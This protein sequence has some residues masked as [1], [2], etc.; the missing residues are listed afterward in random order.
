MQLIKLA[1]AVHVRVTKRLTSV[2]PSPSWHNFVFGNLT[3]WRIRAV[4]VQKCNSSVWSPAEGSAEASEKVPLTLPCCEGRDHSFNALPLAYR[5]YHQGCT[6]IV[7]Q[8][9]L[10]VL[11]MNVF[12]PDIFWPV[13]HL[14]SLHQ[15][16]TI[17]KKK[18]KTALFN[19]FLNHLDTIVLFMLFDE[20]HQD[21]INHN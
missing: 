13:V 21:E 1:S 16:C 15:G 18:T 20:L 12:Y 5:V 8:C 11:T 14:L 17:Q 10:L 7:D 19:I 2:N 4:H 3:K 9:L 6:I